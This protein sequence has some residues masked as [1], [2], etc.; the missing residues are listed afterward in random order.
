MRA[1]VY[2]G[3]L[4]AV[5]TS[6]HVIETDSL[7]KRFG[8]VVAV[9]DLSLSV[10]RGDIYGFLGPNGAGKTTTIQLLLS[11]VRPTS[12]TVRLFGNPPESHESDPC[13]RIGVLLADASLYS[14]LTARE[15]LAFVSRVK[16]A[17]ANPDRLCDRVGLADAIDR[18]AGEFSTG[19]RQRLGLA[20]ALVGEP[21]LL[22]L[23][24]PTSGLD[25]NGTRE[26]R[27]IVREENERGATVFLSSHSL[28]QIEQLCDRVGI[29]NE[30]ELVAEESIAESR[31]A[32]APSLEALFAAHTQDGRM[33]V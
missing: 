7:T 1:I 5:M 26:F 19:M 31:P 12:G 18:P 2:E 20:M 8:E 29:L 27:S 22:I 13:D 10:R 4:P 30:G 28:G 17:D 21:E 24:E 3:E 15:H 16:D 14:N 6:H 23:D 32:D 11:L 33:E 9:R 25:P